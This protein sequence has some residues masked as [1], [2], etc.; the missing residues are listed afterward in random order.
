MVKVSMEGQSSATL[1]SENV[2]DDCKAALLEVRG[3]ILEHLA[4]TNE[5]KDNIKQY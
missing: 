3:E 4:E 5:E 2:H 1:G